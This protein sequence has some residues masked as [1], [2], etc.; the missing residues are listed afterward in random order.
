M[1][2]YPFLSDQWIDEA[3]KIRD[4]FE[5]DAPVAP[6]LRI[7]LAVTG[8]PFGSGS[9]EAH[10][11]S[12]AG[13]VELDHGFLPNPEA[14]VTT[15]YATARSLFVDQDPTAAMSAFMNG[16]I[17]VQGDL[18]KLLALQTSIPQGDTPAA[19][20]AKA[21]ADRIKAITAD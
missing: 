17:R 20:A 8:V 18:A 5:G 7:N 1:T 19:Q 15:D 13:S 4:S 10:L 2:Q 21:A 14:T 9:V 11:D 12:S 16:K 3:R 6:P